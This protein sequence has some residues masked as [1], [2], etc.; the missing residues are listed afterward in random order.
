[1]KTRQADVAPYVTKDRS[2]IRELMHPAVHGNTK[3]SLAHATVPAGRATLLHRHRHTEEL[4]H[5]TEGVG[6]MTLGDDRFTVAPGDTI[7][8][9]P[10]TAHRIENTGT[11]PLML[12]CMCSPAYDHDDTELLETEP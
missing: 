2:E 3:Q 9:R 8:I 7:L 4:Y 11:E 10:G 12:L 5:I 6:R 1:M